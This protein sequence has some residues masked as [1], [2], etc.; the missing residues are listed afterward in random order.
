MLARTPKEG[1][2]LDERIS[3]ELYPVRAPSSSWWIIGR[4][5]SHDVDLPN[6]DGTP[7]SHR[8]GNDGK[9]HSCKVK[10]ADANMFPRK[11]VP[12]KETG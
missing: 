4:V 2:E 10:T 5:I 1:N 11:D 6:E 9:V 8:N 3:Q 7:Y 12:P